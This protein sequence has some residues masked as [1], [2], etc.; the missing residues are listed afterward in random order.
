MGRWTPYVID[1]VRSGESLQC[2]LYDYS[3]CG[4]TSTYHNL[5]IP[6]V[7]LNYLPVHFWKNNKKQRFRYSEKS[8][9]NIRQENIKHISKHSVTEG[10]Q[11][12]KT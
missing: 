8:I 7:Q 6:A 12:Q 9:K 11:I 5:A 3:P 4:E 1:N 10:I 2:K